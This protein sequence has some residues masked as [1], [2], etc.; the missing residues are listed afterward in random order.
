MTSH[1]LDPPLSQTVTP[2]WTPSPSS[3]TYFMDGPYAAV[4]LSISHGPVTPIF[5][6]LS[7]YLCLPVCL[8]VTSRSIQDCLSGGSV[9]PIFPLSVCMCVCVCLYVAV[10]LF[11]SRGP[12]NPLYPQAVCL[13]M[14]VCMYV[15]LH[16]LLLPSPS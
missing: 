10:C 9:S 16:W 8:S 15:Y 1:A 14:Y 2:S 3:M 7:V 12:V 11:I 6:C 5:L 4:C 13:Y